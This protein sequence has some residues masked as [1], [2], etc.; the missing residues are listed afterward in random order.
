M[1]EPVATRAAGSEAAGVAELVAG[2][3]ASE[4]AESGQRGRD[5]GGTVAVAGQ[6]RSRPTIWRARM[7]APDGGP[8]GIGIKSATTRATEESL[9]GT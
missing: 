8:T 2:R 5:G 4:L 7:D 1:V 6:R 9:K 3:P